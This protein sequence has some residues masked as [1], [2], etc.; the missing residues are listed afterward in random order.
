[1]TGFDLER[2]TVAAVRPDGE[3][4]SIPY[5]SLIVAA[6]VGQSYF[7]HDEFAEFAPG[8]KTLADA[9]GSADA[10]PGC[11]RDGRAGGR[12]RGA[13][14]RGSP[15]RS[16]A[17]ARPASRSPVRSPSSPGARWRGNFRRFDPSR[18]RGCSCS[19]AASRSWPRSATGCPT[20]ATRELEQTG[21]RDPHRVDRHR[22][23]RDRRRREG[24]R[25]GTSRASRRRTTIWAAGV[26]GVAAGAA[27]G[28]R[29]PAP[30]AT[31]PA[32][33]RCSPTARCPGIPR[34][35]R[36]AT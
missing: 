2:R 21:R 26:A 18:R 10:D 12:P 22:R 14:R 33:S 24:R 11:V 9:L 19:T 28:R 7:G 5:D 30:S 35:S 32:G 36:S 31:A 34:C 16:S 20:S 17:A 8:M 29:R 25:T 23:R 3:A 1:M 4:R 27:A 13:A 6:G 15:S